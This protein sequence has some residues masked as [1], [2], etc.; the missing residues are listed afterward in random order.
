M[1]SQQAGRVAREASR[2]RCRLGQAVE[3]VQTWLAAGGIT[4]G[5]VFRSVLKGGRVQPGHLPGRFVAAIVSATATRAGLDPAAYAGHSLRAGM[6]T[7]AAEHGASVFKIQEV[8]RHK[9]INVLSGYVRRAPRG[10]PPRYRE[11]AM[12]GPPG[13]GRPGLVLCSTVCCG[14]C[15]G[16]EHVRWPSAEAL[17]TGCPPGQRARSRYRPQTEAVG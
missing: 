9:S 3:A 12:P 16:L 8:S 5:P 7:S 13:W 2:N 4:E 17:R 14:F 1:A 10:I 15:D 6:I 11:S